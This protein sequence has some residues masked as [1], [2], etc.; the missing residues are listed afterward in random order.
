M[1][2]VLT[3]IATIAFASL[4]AQTYQVG[5][6]SL[7]FKDPSR[8]GGYAISGGI[9]VGT[10][11]RDVG[12]EV[13]YPAATAGNNVAIAT[14]TFPVVVVGHGFVMTWDAYTDLWTDLVQNGY[15]VCLPRTEGGTS[16]S[17][18]DFGK[19]LAFI[20]SQMITTMMSTAPGSPAPS[21]IGKI[22]PRVALSGHSMGGGSSFLGAQNNATI[23][24]MVNFAAANTNPSSQHAAKFVTVPSLVISGQNDCVAP[25]AQHQ[26]PEYDS[27]IL[28]HTKAY[29]SVVGGD[30]CSFG[31]RSSAT[32]MFGQGT[33][34]PQPTI[35]EAQQ[36]SAAYMAARLWLDYF[37]KQD[38]SAWP[39]FKDSL[40]LSTRFI[41]DNLVTDIVNPVISAAGT[42]LTC[43]TPA[44]SYQW[45][46]NG[47]PVGGATASTYTAIA[48]GNYSCEVKYVYTNCPY[49]SN[50]VNI[51]TTGISSV[52]TTQSFVLFP[53]PGQDQFMVSY[54]AESGLPVSFRVYD[55]TGNLV[56]KA[57]S[58][59]SAVGQQTQVL[60]LEQLSPGAYLLSVE[61]SHFHGVYKLIK[62]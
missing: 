62:N 45:Y 2:K 7:N 32:C 24:T 59:G 38:C 39:K 35:T 11:G 40:N 26:K 14:G 36:K 55:L 19:D 51:S 20:G 9:Q 27:L 34:S 18:T 49:T 43:T 21:F 60:N 54:Y 15:I 37:L 3:L 52:Y 58:D 46:L 28:T 6:C 10:S 31:S 17:H 12:T 1:K 56:Y 22:N 48:N 5:H 50:V 16:P 8:T 42:V 13:Y 33:C 53:N 4:E 30:H 61:H 44:A 29:M 47:S 23:T 25:P 41:N 57:S